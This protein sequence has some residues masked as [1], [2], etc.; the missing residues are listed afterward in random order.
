[1]RDPR[2]IESTGVVRGLSLATTIAVYVQLILGAAIRH[3]ERGVLACPNDSSTITILDGYS[4]RQLNLPDN[5]SRP[6]RV[7]ESRSGQFWTSP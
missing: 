1:M 6:I 2:P 5:V 4:T 3:S 7:Y